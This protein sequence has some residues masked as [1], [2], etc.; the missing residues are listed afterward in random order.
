V[1]PF[2]QVE[3]VERFSYSRHSI[4]NLG[5]RDGQMKA[6]IDYIDF[7]HPVLKEQVR[8]ISALL[9]GIL[10][11]GLPPTR[12]VL[13]TYSRNQFAEL[14]NRSLNELFQVC[15]GRNS[16]RSNATGFRFDQTHYAE[17]SDLPAPSATEHPSDDVTQSTKSFW[18]QC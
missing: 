12:I 18:R 2:L 14:R 13:E 5:R 15:T 10:E 7:V 4:H 11:N 16:Q 8:T 9:P 1:S 17:N 3:L 6:F